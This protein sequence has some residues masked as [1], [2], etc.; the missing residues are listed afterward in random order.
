MSL[1]HSKK[2]KKNRKC[3]YHVAKIADLQG[4]HNIGI[5]YYKQD[6]YHHEKFIDDSQGIDFTYFTH[7]DDIVMLLPIPEPIRNGIVFPRKINLDM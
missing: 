4:E 1:F 3:R 2:R 7:I 5:N 6:T